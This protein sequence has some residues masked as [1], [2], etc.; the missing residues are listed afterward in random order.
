[1]KTYLE[2]A[3]EKLAIQLGNFA[4]K[5]NLYQA[6][7]G[8]TAEE[9]TEQLLPNWEHFQFRLAYQRKSSCSQ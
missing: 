5:I 7:F 9:T 4:S 3:D 2:R 8:L 6:D 1:M